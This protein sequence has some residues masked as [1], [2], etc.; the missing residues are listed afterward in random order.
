MSNNER[1][2]YRDLIELLCDETSDRDELIS[3]S[4]P[5]VDSSY[6]CGVLAGLQIAE[7]IIHSCFSDQ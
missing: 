3:N 7:K 1:E 6:H 4:I 5:G 2:F